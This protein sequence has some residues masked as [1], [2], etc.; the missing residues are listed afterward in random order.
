MPPF[1]RREVIACLAA[2]G[3]VPAG[4]GLAQSSAPRAGLKLGPAKPFSYDML[5]EHARKLAETAYQAAEPPAKA[6]IQGVDFDKVQKIR[7]RAEDALWRGVAGADPIA[8]FHLNKYSADP[9]K[10]FA[11]GANA[12]GA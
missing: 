12:T 4:R 8:F 9:V 3:L 7:F 11:L 1:D 2:L 5:K 10:I 6:I